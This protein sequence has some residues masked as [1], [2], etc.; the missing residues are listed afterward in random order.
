MRLLLL[1]AFALGTYEIWMEKT[2]PEVRK[3]HYAE[4][5]KAGKNTAKSVGTVIKKE[6]DLI[7]RSK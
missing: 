6:I 1:F 3:K 2:P 4:L 7:K 5:K